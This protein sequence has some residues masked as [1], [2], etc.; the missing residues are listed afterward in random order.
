[1]DN[2]VYVMQDRATLESDLSGNSLAMMMGCDNSARERIFLGR[3]ATT[4][5]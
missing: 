5:G 3:G 2:Y 1:M 4:L